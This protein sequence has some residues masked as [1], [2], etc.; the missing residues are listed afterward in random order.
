[1]LIHIFSSLESLFS[2]IV[3]D[4]D[5]SSFFSISGWPKWPFYWCNKRSFIGFGWILRYN[6]DKITVSLFKARF[7]ISCDPI[8]LRIEK[9]QISDMTQQ[10]NQNST[11]MEM[12]Q[13]WPTPL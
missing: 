4:I 8:G 9:V 13:I 7:L 3:S 1:M 5:Y 10:G 11:V 12:R 6:F 2:D